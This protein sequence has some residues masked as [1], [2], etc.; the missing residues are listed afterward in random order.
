MRGSSVSH[1][2]AG[3]WVRDSPPQCFSEAGLRERG[4][5]R[6]QEGELHD[7]SELHELQ[8]L[9]LLHA[10]FCELLGSTA[11]LVLTGVGDGRFSR[12]FH[13]IFH[14]LSFFREV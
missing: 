5:E 10:K 1:L 14:V 2:I 13:R 4:R 6:G 3:F 8:L 12:T 11:R 9:P 7:L